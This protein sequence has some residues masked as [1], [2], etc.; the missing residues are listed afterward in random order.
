MYWISFL[1]N[2]IS[3]KY[4]Y[5]IDNHIQ[6]SSYYR[7]E[8][9]WCSQGGKRYIYYVLV[10]VRWSYFPLKIYTP[11]ETYNETY[12]IYQLAPA[13]YSYNFYA[14]QP[15]DHCTY[16]SNG[17][18]ITT[19]YVQNISSQLSRDYNFPG[20]RQIDSGNSGG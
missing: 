18:P 4:Y 14:N 9:N 5:F 15:T 7:S 2:Y 20:S 12:R 3:K 11:C 10:Q 19:T 1:T 13:S 8:C 6:P 17:V 16:T